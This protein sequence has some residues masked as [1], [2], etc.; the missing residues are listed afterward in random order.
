MNDKHNHSRACR[1]R[2]SNKSNNNISSILPG[3]GKNTHKKAR[4]VL[5]KIPRTQLHI[6]SRQTGVRRE[7]EPVMGRLF[8]PVAATDD[9]SV[10]EHIFFSPRR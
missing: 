7:S 4:R 1:D 2:R 6:I 8:Y 9:I 3:V 10:E 5:I